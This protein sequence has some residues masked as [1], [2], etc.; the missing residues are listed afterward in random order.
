MKK[1]FRSFLEILKEQEEMKVQILIWKEK[2]LHYLIYHLQTQV[3]KCQIQL[4]LQVLIK[5]MKVLMWKLKKNLFQ[6]VIINFINF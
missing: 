5:R 6:K 4:Q 1:T 2:L 3:F